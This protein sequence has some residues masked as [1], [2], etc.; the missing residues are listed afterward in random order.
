M[1]TKAWLWGWPGADG[2]TLGL[3]PVKAKMTALVRLSMRNEIENATIVVVI[4]YSFPP[5]DY[6]KVPIARRGASK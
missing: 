1:K 6:Q 5:N 4:G 2:P 3:L